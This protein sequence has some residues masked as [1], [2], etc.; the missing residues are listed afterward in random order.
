MRTAII[1]LGLA[2][3]S[4]APGAFGTGSG[5]ASIDG[6]PA[7]DSGRDAALC[8]SWLST[9][10]DPCAL[11]S[12]T[13]DIQ[14]TTTGSPYTFDTTSGGG[15]LVDK[16]GQPVAVTS[17]DVTQAS[18]LHAALWTMNDFTIDGSVA[19]HVV[20]SKPLIVASWGS[21]EVSGTID[22]GSHAGGRTGAGANPTSCGTHAAMAGGDGASGNGGG[23]G[24]GNQGNG[25]AGGMGDANCSGTPPCTVA[26]GLRGTAV[27]PSSTSIE[28]G[29]DGATSGAAAGTRAAGGKGG[30][31]ILLAA[32]GTI[33]VT[34][35]V[36]AGGAGGAGDP[37]NQ[38]STGGG[39]GGA[40]GFIGLEA[41]AVSIASSIVAANGGGGGGAGD[42]ASTGT[43][44]TDGGGT[45]SAASGGPAGG[46]ATNGGSGSSRAVLDG[47]ATTEATMNGGGG[48]GGGG[49][50]FVLYWST[51]FVEAGAT[52]SP[53]AAAGP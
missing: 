37:N 7:D 35:N 45:T 52:V 33:T 44:G 41:A 4:F 11:P 15:T 8:A 26:G 27:A 43:A 47:S 49:A 16:G 48:G 30:G 29:C 14:L 9:H 51:S 5:D 53:P 20:G 25:G 32:R 40:G 2:G 23:G 50:G 42:I 36:L 22:A 17:I 46:A 6:A 10:F 39:G 24:G 31:A 13:G 3:C 19:L 28:G 38:V 12:P 1:A 21:I 34:G 18:G